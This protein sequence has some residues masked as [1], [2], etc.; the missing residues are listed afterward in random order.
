MLLMPSD[1]PL[2][3]RGPPGQEIQANVSMGQRP[4]LI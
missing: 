4:L 3:W 2:Y 1:V